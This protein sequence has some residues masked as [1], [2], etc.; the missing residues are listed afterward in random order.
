MKHLT[1]QEMKLT[2]TVLIICLGYF[3]LV[4]PKIIN[5]FIMNYESIPYIQLGFNCLECLNYS[6]KFFVLA[7]YNLQY[8]NAYIFIFKEVNN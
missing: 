2:K 3:I 7:G 8:R 1:P 5:P 6:F 4:T